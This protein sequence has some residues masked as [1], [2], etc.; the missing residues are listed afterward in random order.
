MSKEQKQ[1]ANSCWFNEGVACEK[2]DCQGCG[3]NPE[4]AR[5]RSEELFRMM[6]IER[7]TAEKE[8]K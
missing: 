1:G 3:G 8:G 4:V 2:Q 6:G 5:Q 7:G